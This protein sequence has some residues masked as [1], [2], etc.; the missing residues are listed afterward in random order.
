MLLVEWT[1]LLTHVREGLGSNLRPQNGYYGYL[2]RI[3]SQSLPADVRTSVRSRTLQLSFTSFPS[4]FRH[5]VFWATDSVGKHNENRDRKTRCNVRTTA[6][7]SLNSD[8]VK[9]VEVPPE[10]WRPF[11]KESPWNDTKYLIAGYVDTTSQNGD[12]QISSWFTPSNVRQIWSSVQITEYASV[13]DDGT[14]CTLVLWIAHWKSI[15]CD[16]TVLNTFGSYFEIKRLR[17]GV[18]LKLRLCNTSVY[19]QVC[20]AAAGSR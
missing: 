12:L 17:G 7:R 15:W 4:H 11:C 10:G 3:F 5:C 19:Q 8:R 6:E 16:Q 13:L 1:V 20:F 2:L 14:L 18:H 9:L